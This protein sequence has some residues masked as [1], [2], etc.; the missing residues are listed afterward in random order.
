MQPLYSALQ[1]NA[2][3]KF[4]L[5]RDQK[6]F[7]R[8]LA[9]DNIAHMR[10]RANLDYEFEKRK[11]LAEE[12]ERKLWNERGGKETH[13]EKMKQLKL[14]TNLDTMKL[15]NTLVSNRAGVDQM[16]LN[17]QR[18]SI[19]GNQI[20]SMQDE[21]D[22]MKGRRAEDFLRANI[23]DND[24]GPN[25]N[26]GESGYDWVTAL[27]EGDISIS[28]GPTFSKDKMSDEDIINTYNKLTGPQ[29]IEFARQVGRR[30]GQTFDD[31]VS[32]A[33]QELQE[34][35][36]KAME[37]LT[38]LKTASP[39]T[40]RMAESNLKS[41]LNMFKDVIPETEM[42]LQML[43]V[44]TA[45]NFN[46]EDNSVN[47]NRQSQAYDRTPAPSVNSADGV[48]D[49]VDKTMGDVPVKLN[50]A[51][52]DYQNLD[53]DA[54]RIMAGPGAVKDLDKYNVVPQIT[55]PAALNVLRAGGTF[56]GKTLEQLI[57]E[58]AIKSQ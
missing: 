2:N 41:Y 52:M 55:D 9:R 1:Q 25:E 54:A 26:F 18:A 43:D 22:A 8:Q 15:M 11:K 16:K 47:N 20:K 17:N 46:P 27:D 34:K 42:N 51:G 37:L 32:V 30:K 33:E 10:R 21:F 38:S 58:G 31:Q 56:K 28:G 48:G 39:D 3:N 49:I 53:P 7:D 45:P 35:I 29:K 57:A 4:T 13:E 6:Q 23:E 44:G 19:L 14:K 24:L 40:I 36:N 50:Q 12:T 5:N